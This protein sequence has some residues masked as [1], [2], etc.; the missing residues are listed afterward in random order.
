MKRP[1]SNRRYP[2]QKLDH[3]TEAAADMLEYLDDYEISNIS[4]LS[5]EQVEK[6]REENITSDKE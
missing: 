4:G 1:S 2:R 5:I 3:L 6:M